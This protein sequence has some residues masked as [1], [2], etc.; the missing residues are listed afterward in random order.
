MQ[1]MLSILSSFQKTKFKSWPKYLGIRLLV[2]NKAPKDK[3]A[4]V[5]HNSLIKTSSLNLFK[6]TSNRLY[7]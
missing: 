1:L 4:D 7:S 6:T 3:A 5:S 2:D